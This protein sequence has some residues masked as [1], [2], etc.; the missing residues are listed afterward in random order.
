MPEVR[1]GAAMDRR[2]ECRRVHGQRRR[3][4]SSGARMS[5]PDG[6]NRAN[7]IAD[8]FIPFANNLPASWPAAVPDLLGGLRDLSALR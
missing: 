7:A 1:H 2:R 4:I 3:T 5:Y 6:Q 8:W